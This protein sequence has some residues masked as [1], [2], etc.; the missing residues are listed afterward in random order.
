MKFTDKME[1]IKQARA[2]GFMSA[3]A[4]QYNVDTTKKSTLW[5]ERVSGKNARFVCGKIVS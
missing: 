5:L 3:R 2:N 4:A 1:L